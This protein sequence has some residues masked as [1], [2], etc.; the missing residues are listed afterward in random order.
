MERPFNHAFFLLVIVK[1]FLHVPSIVL[2]TDV[3][4]V[5]RKTKSLNSWNMYSELMLNYTV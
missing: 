2:N 3:T 4:V 5:T 1:Y